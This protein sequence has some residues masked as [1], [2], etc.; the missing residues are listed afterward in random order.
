[1]AAVRDSF[2]DLEFHRMKLEENMAQLQKSLKLW[3]TWEAE[4]E[5]FKE[6]ILTLGSNPKWQDLDSAGKEYGDFQEIKDLVYDGRGQKRDS[7]Q[8]IGLLSRRI[9]YV[10]ENVKA[11]SRRLETA[12]EKFLAATVI[13]QPEVRDEEGLPLTEIREELD[14]DGNVTSSSTIVPGDSTPQMLEVLRKAGVKDLPEFRTK[15]FAS[16]D[17]ED[18]TKARSNGDSSVQDVF[19]VEEDPTLKKVATVEIANRP[20]ATS[21]EPSELP[22]WPA[23]PRKKTVT[24]ANDTKAFSAE[25]KSSTS[26][27]KIK[28]KK[29]PIRLAF[30]DPPP[31]FS[32]ENDEARQPE[33]PP[34]IPH[35][36]SPDDAS[37]RSQMLQYSMGEIGA[38]VAEMDIDESGSY[39]SYSGDEE[40]GEDYDSSIDGDEDEYGRT[41]RPVIDDNYRKQMEELEKKLNGKMME[42][43]GPNPDIPE[44]IA[45][46]L[47]L[48]KKEA[49]S[50]QESYP[51]SSKSAIK[52]VRFA[53][54]LDVADSRPIKHDKINAKL[55]ENLPIRP[56]ADKIV[57]RSTPASMPIT[58]I[59]AKKPSKFK[60]ARSGPPPASPY[61]E[62]YNHPIPTIATSPSLPPQSTLPTGSEGRTHA[63]T[64]IERSPIPDSD[65]APPPEPNDLDPV[66]H[67]QEIAAGYYKMRNRQIQREGGYRKMREE[68]EEMGED[69]MME[70]DE[71]GN[72]K[73]VSLF[74]KARMGKLGGQDVNS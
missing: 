21:V 39:S 35:D 68:S 48:S 37:M 54:E 63:P 74:K 50:K 2:V 57:E 69:D 1:M 24:F 62:S 45:E 10:Q 6:E 15:E 11:I 25:D 65:P 18:V 52:A 34:N 31:E 23:R 40:D 56:I 36:E 49:N 4:Y 71:A 64:I 70:E 7:Q 26:H 53:E 9:D 46:K 44:N 73:K 12:N 51:L 16:R 38:I 20:S 67:R 66:M 43:R 17:T 27:S 14:E 61:P 28:P 13:S 59:P 72:A 5:G 3:Q 58:A 8:I 55:V 32:N 33:C 42:K 60:A 19:T 22:E 29:E 41:K 30:H 47:I